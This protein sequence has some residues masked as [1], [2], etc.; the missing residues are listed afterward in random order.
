MDLRRFSRIK[1]LF[2]VCCLPIFL[3]ACIPAALVLGATAGG[4]VIYDKR[5][6]NTILHDQEAATQAAH[7]I[8][9]DP[10]LKKGAHI[11]L[12]VFNHVLLLVGQT[13]TQQQRDTAYNLVTGIKNVNRVYNEITIQKPTSV[14]R[15][16]KDAWITTKVK[17]EM[18]A[19]K[20]LRSTQIKVVTE[21]AVVYLMGVIT[22]Q[23]AN[24]AADVARRVHGVTKVVKVFQYPQ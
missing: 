11:V 6:M 13:K 19:K 22:H 15:R 3:S 9:N 1:K 7:R 5:S 23:Q 18:L 4:A 21:N 8:N 10:T 2:I 12:A 14:W 24:L 17:S 16:S 20:G